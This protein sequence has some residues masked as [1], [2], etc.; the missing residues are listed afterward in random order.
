MPLRRIEGEWSGG[1]RAFSDVGLAAEADRADGGVEHG[2][3]CRAAL[4]GCA[5]TNLEAERGASTPRAK[6][7]GFHHPRSA[8][9]KHRRVG[10]RFNEP[11]GRKKTS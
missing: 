3:R 9:R 4:I 8:R 10:P 7:V 11:D 1:I 2:G 6:Y 5:E